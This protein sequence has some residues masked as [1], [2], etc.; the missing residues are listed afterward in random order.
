MRPG[1]PIALALAG[2]LL[3]GLEPA[4]AQDEATHSI[5]AALDVEVSP[6][7]VRVGDLVE[8]TLVLTTDG[9]LSGGP[10]FPN[11][12]LHWGTA[13]IRGTGDIVRTGGEGGA[14]RFEQTVQLAAFRPGDVVLPPTAVELPTP[15]GT[16]P[17]IVISAP[18]S[19]EIVSVL[20][21]EGDGTIEPKP[22]ESPRALPAG[23][24]FWW[25]AGILAA[26]VAVLLALIL[27]K[28]TP[29]ETFVGEV[30]DPWEALEQALARLATA[31]DPE[32]VFTGLSLELRRYLGRC[33]AF[34]AAESTTTELRRRLLRSGLPSA[35]CGDVV[36]LLLEAD[37]VKFA[38]QAPKAGRLEQC[39]AEAHDAAGEVR[40]FLR[41]SEP[42]ADEERAA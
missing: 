37:S 33:L 25:T 5:G 23:R 3:G 28:R 21:R 24:A 18:A 20:P 27:R 26:L 36:G 7:T 10:M 29:K 16:E 19:F 11:W 38:K 40:A 1:R 31:T 22:P 9:E 41:P 30:L 35:I 13:E 6:K 42:E 12:Q 15:A 4:R 17:Q 39:L 2:L 32:T 14:T 8:A 34:P